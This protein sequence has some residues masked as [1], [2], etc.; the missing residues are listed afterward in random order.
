[1]L[2]KMQPLQGEK[3]DYGKLFSETSPFVLQKL[4]DVSA[5]QPEQFMI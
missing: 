4:M 5:P 1:M 2:I 3:N